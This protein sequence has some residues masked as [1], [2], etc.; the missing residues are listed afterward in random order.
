MF[1]IAEAP[2]KFLVAHIEK[3]ARWPGFLSHNLKQLALE[4]RYAVEALI[5]LSHD[6]QIFLRLT[7]NRMV[8][9]YLNGTTKAYQVV[10]VANKYGVGEIC[11][12]DVWAAEILGEQN[13][14]GHEILN[15]KRLEETLLR[16]DA[17]F[18][19]YL[20][21]TE[22]HYFLDTTALKRAL[23]ADHPI[24]FETAT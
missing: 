8:H 20:E 1:D 2:R 14:N 23:E 19:R 5:S 6:D 13:Q 3:S 11:V 21:Q 4:C 22:E 10:K 7:R 16:F 18:Q 12:T 15:R 24:F 9:G 17:P